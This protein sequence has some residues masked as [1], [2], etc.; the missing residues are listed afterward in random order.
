MLIQTLSTWLTQRQD[1]ELYLQRTAEALG[2]K[3]GRPLAKMD[4]E[5]MGGGE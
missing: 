1:N 5:A 3:V 4:K 2:R